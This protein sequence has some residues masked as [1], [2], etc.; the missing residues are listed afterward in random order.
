[1]N[2]ERKERIKQLRERLAGLSEAER[3]T[4][5]ARGMIATVEGRVLSLHNTLL[6][7]IQSNGRT[8]TIVAG[9]QQWRRAGKSVRKGEHGYMIWF[10]VG[11]KDE[12]TGDIVS[13][14]TYYTATVF[15]ISQTEPI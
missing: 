15:D 7:Y 2:A 10:P 3:Q 9:F 1:M 12:E 8:P 11:Q 4:L 14:D 13:A 5:A 6:V